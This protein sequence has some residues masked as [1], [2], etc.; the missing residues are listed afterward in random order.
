ME[1]NT[2]TIHVE[3]EEPLRRTIMIIHKSVSMELNLTS[4]AGTTRQ[5]RKDTKTSIYHKD[6]LGEGN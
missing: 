2:E 6:L 5:K 1:K 4:W 3:W